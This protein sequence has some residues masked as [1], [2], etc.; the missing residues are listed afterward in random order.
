MDSNP[1]PSVLEKDAMT[2]MPAAII[3]GII[4]TCFSRGRSTLQ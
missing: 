3:V 2:T 1:G 4:V